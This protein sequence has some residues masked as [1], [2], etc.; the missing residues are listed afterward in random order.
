MGGIAFVRGCRNALVG[1]QARLMGGIAF[2]RGF[3]VMVS[4]HDFYILY[5]KA[6]N[7]GGGLYR[8]FVMECTT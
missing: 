1:C 8:M 4:Q 3:L 6:G 7:A 2:I 5:Q